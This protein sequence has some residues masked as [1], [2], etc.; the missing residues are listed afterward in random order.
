MAQWLAQ[1]WFDLLSSVGILFAAYTIHVDAKARRI[2]NFLAIVSNYQDIWKECFRNPSLT[3]VLDPS[4]D[5]AKQPPTPTE[6]LFVGLV[7]SQM[8]SF[9]YA[10]KSDPVVKLEGSRQDMAQFLSLP[11]PKAVWHTVKPLQNRD[12]AAFIDSALK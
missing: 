2:G 6:E 11:V 8:S 7:I 9:Y 10:A 12:F 1:N 5:A 4:A 3:R